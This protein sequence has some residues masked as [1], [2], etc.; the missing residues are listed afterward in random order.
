MPLSLSMDQQQYRNP[1]YHHIHRNTRSSHEYN[2]PQPQCRVNVY[3][4]SY[5]T[6]TVVHQNIISSFPPS[7]NNVQRACTSFHSS[8]GCSWRA[9]GIGG[10]SGFQNTYSSNCLPWHRGNLQI[11][12]LIYYGSAQYYSGERHRVIMALFL[13]FS[14]F[15]IMSLDISKVS[16]YKLFHFVFK[17][18]QVNTS[19]HW[20]TII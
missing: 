12:I 16:L 18:M 2:F 9:I 4:H 1:I 11:N 19:E 3:Q 6:W 7:L 5:F 20:L 17:R 10:S 13:L 8:E 14:L 15:V